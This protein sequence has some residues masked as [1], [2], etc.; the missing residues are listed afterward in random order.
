M[1]NFTVFFTLAQ[2]ALNVYLI[3]KYT[4]S[5]DIFILA[6]FGI[7]LNGVLFLL[8]IFKHLS[9]MVFVMNQKTASAAR[10]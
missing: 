8:Q 3:F 7:L 4:P 9:T 5:E 10:S 6:C 2:T 1:S